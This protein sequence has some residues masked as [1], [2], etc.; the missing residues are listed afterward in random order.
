[1]KRSLIS[2]FWKSSARTIKFKPG[3]AS[4]ILHAFYYQN[5]WK[6]LP[7]SR[8]SSDEE[9]KRPDQEGVLWKNC[10]RKVGRELY[11]LNQLCSLQQ[12]I[13]RF[14]IVKFRVGELQPFK[15][16]PLL[17]CGGFWP[18]EKKR[19]LGLNLQDT[20]CRIELVDLDLNFPFVKS[21][22]LPA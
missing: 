16:T 2:I 13:F 10:S 21:I 1:M 9:R 20:A 3:I 19:L 6:N 5:Y 8:I 17:S 22:L 7:L 15:W 4:S 14:M 12:K 18:L 11:S